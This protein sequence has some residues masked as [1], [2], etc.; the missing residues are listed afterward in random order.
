MSS[1]KFSVFVEG[2]DS[3]SRALKLADPLTRSRVAEAIRKNTKQVT[4]EARSKAPKLTGEM[5]STIRD[6]YSE[7]GMVGMVKV[8]E[9]KLPRRSQAKT[10][11]GQATH[12]SRRRS[13]GKG[14]YAPV[15]DRGDPRRNRKAQPFLSEPFQADKPQAVSDINRA[16]EKAVDDIAGTT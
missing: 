5:A 4:A 10:A 14:A 11:R 1:V 12:R 3:L 16:L 8:G 13:T 9:G 7:D 2:V 15:I 6:E